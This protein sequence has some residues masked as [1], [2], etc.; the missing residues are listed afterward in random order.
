MLNGK[1]LGWKKGCSATELSYIAVLL[2][3]VAIQ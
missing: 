3:H 1:T 2:N